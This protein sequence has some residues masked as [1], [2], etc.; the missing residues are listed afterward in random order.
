VPRTLETFDEGDRRQGLHQLTGRSEDEERYSPYMVDSAT[1]G[2]LRASFREQGVAVLGPPAI[3]AA[4][5]GDLVAE[6]LAQRKLQT[7]RVTETGEDPWTLPQDLV[8]VHLGDSARELIDSHSTATLL[9]A[10]TDWSTEPAWNSSCFTFYD[11]PGTFIGRHTDRL[12]LCQLGILLYL[13]VQWQESQPGPGLQLNIDG[14]GNVP[15]TKL[16]IDSRANRIVVFHGA[17][18]VHHRPPMGVGESLSLLNCCFRATADREPA[19]RQGDLAA[20]RTERP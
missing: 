12:D 13:E 1:V 6:S 18:F 17:R 10:I 9:K 3:T 16:Q 4:A 8:R 2:K 19:T 14:D 11:R 20:R 15:W 5:H 7:W